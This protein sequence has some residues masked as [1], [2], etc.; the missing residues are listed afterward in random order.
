MTGAG[1]SSGSEELISSASGFASARMEE[2]LNSRTSSPTREDFL[3]TIYVGGNS[4]QFEQWP[5]GVS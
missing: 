4:M 1:R 2:Y 5:F 3:S